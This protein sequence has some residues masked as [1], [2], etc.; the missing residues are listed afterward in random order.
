[1][2]EG[3]VAS[4]RAAGAAQSD[5]PTGT[6]EPAI[7]DLAGAVDAAAD[8]VRT[9][10]DDARAA[11]EGLR[12]AI[13]AIH[14]AGLVAIIRRLRDDPV[15]LSLLLG[16]ADEP[17]VRMLLALHGLISAEPASTPAPAPEPGHRRSL[18]LTP[19]SRQPASE[20]DEEPDDDEGD[21]G[22]E[23]WVRTYPVAELVDGSVTPVRLVSR[24]GV[25][26]PAIVVNVDG[27]FTAFRDEC[28]HQ[29]LPLGGALLDPP[30]DTLT[31]PW[32]GYC[33]DAKSGD[34]LSAPGMSLEPLPLRVDQDAVWIR[35]WP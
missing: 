20:A 28:A 27:R 25:E 19:V 24:D 18:T 12:D 9:L 1:M 11:A 29:G 7:E 4:E 16:L 13:E 30:A 22:I 5:N 35:I 23:G 33:F 21:N 32:H 15:G 3:V 34:C 8:R 10:D 31:C 2:A 26:T 14:R 6:G 17:V